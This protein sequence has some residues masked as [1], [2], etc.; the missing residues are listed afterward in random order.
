MT[1]IKSLGQLAEL[2]RARRFVTRIAVAVAEDAHTLDSLGRAVNE[3]FVRAVLIGDSQKIAALCTQE[4]LDPAAFEI[5]DQPDELAAAALA[6]QLVK[7]GQADSVMKGLLST[8]KFLRAVMHKERGLLPAKTVMSHVCVLEIPRYHKMLFIS[9]TAVLPFP[10]LDQKVAMI[11]YCVA[12]A[13]GFGI[14]C[15]KVAL[16]TATDKVIGSIPN[17]LEYAQI[18]RMAVRGQIKNC[19]IDGPLDFFLA[20]D[21][22]AGA[23]KGVQ[24]PIAGDADILI[25]PNLECSNSFYKGLMLFAQGEL[26]GLIQGT[27]QPVIVMSRSESTLSKYYSIALACKLAGDQ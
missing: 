26:A 2:V 4:G 13:R 24:T 20:C 11:N 12:M 27:Q 8:D 19:V 7:S 1:E 25:F 17:T 5:I 16:I 15:P 3:G 21:P 14:A 22:S 18:S 6:V 9:D 10:D 23:I